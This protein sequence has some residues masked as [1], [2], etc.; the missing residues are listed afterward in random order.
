MH[1]LGSCV[2]RNAIDIRVVDNDGTSNSTR[3]DASTA[4]SGQNV[5]HAPDQN[6]ASRAFD[7]LCATADI[8]SETDALVPDSTWHSLRYA[9]RRTSLNTPPPTTTF[10]H[11]LIVTTVQAAARVLTCM[12]GLGTMR[13]ACAL[14]IL[15]HVL[16]DIRVCRARV[17]F[18]LAHRLLDTVPFLLK[19]LW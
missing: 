4:I 13:A 7:L 15:V 16:R 2:H 6:V 18:K 14:G 12:P 19:A 1:H 5:T 8:Q 17:Q 11:Y 10:K 3:T 9:R